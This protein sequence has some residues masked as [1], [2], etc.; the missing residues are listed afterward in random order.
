MA[1]LQSPNISSFVSSTGLTQAVPRTIYA[2]LVGKAFIACFHLTVYES[3]CI[4]SISTAW[5]GVL[6]TPLACCGKQHHFLSSL[7]PP[8]LASFD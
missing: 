4:F 7:E 8:H 3:T 5:W 1:I 2:A 6:L